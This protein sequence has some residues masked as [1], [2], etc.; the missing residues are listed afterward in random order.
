MALRMEEGHGDK[1]KGHGDSP[2]SLHRNQPT[3]SCTSAPPDPKTH[4]V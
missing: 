3:N 1:L 2:W 4:P